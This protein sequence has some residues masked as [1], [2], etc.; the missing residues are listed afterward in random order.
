MYSLFEAID[1]LDMDSTFYINRENY[2]KGNTIFRFNFAPD[3]SSGCGTVG[4]VNAIKYGSMRINIR[5]SRILDQPITALMFCE[6][7]KIMEIDKKQK[8]NT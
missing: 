6:S 4:H 3:S 2:S 7:D 1:M 8:S 5:F